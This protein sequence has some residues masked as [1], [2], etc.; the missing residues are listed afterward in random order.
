MESQRVTELRW[1]VIKD[2]L[3][4]RRAARDWTK[5]GFIRIAENGDPLWKL[6]RGGWMN[7]HIIEARVAPGGKELWIKVE[8]K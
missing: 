5:Q 8:G 1:D 2:V 3:R 7:R 6:H 4:Y